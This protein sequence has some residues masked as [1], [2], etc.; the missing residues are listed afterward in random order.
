MEYKGL[1]CG[2]ILTLVQFSIFPWSYTQYHVNKKKSQKQK[3]E[4]NSCNVGLQDLIRNILCSLAFSLTYQALPCDLLKNGQ[5][6]S[7]PLKA[8]NVIKTALN[9][10]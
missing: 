6:F 5:S 8:R 4:H 1:C 10:F 7:E 9:R 3:L 2:T